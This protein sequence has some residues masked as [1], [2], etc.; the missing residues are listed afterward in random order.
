[1]D[2]IKVILNGDEIEVDVDLTLQS[3]LNSINNT[4]KMIVVE[5]NLN[6]VPKEEYESCY[7]NDG[8]KIEIVSFFGG[9]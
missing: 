3:L 1:M 8:D 4:N 9:G 6:I 2:K 7:I 5:K